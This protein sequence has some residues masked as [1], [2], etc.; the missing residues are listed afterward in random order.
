VRAEQAVGAYQEL[1]AR[2]WP[3]VPSSEK[4]EALSQLRTALVNGITTYV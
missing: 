2:D 3:N 1:A 4:T